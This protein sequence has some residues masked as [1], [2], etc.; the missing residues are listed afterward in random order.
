[1]FATTLDF[2]AGPE[3]RLAAVAIESLLQER[4]SRYNPLVLLGAPGTGKTHLARG[5]AE[6][7]AA[8]HSLPPA[9]VVYCTASD[10]ANDLKAAIEAETTQKFRERVRQASLLVIE[11]LTQLQTRRVAQQELIHSLDAVVDQG[12]Q[13][14][15]TSHTAPNE[16]S[17]VLPSFAADWPLD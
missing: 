11:N 12:G 14:V 10:F 9:S 1:M 16:S 17:T 13:V 4:P 8:R 15:V 5:L 6:F 2:I 7:W 3:N